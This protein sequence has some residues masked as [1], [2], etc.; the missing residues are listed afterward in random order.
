MQLIGYAQ[1]NIYVIVQFVMVFIV[2]DLG[3][4]ELQTH[5]R[6][7]TTVTTFLC[8]HYLKCELI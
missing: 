4:K 7:N 3:A 5:S 8:G 2:L 6:L 1:Q